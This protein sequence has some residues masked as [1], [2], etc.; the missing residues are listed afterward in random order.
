MYRSLLV[1]LSLS[2]LCYGACGKK[3]P[4]FIPEKSFPLRVEA[5]KGI[6]E[7]GSVILTGVVPGAEAGS[8]DVAGCTIYHSR[9]SLDAPPCDGCPV[10][11]TKLKTLRGAVLSGDR[12]RCEIPEIDQAGI[13][14]IRVRLVD[15]EGIEGPPSEQIKLVLPDD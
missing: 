10:N 14:F 11:L 8:L 12:L 1:F 5:L 7:N 2:V 15:V 3:G 4:P 9:Y 13:H 6:A